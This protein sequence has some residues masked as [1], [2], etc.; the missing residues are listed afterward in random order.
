[1][2]NLLIYL[3]PDHKFNEEYEKLAKIVIENSL[4]YWRKADIMLVTNFPYEFAGVVA[5][6]VG[7]ETICPFY[8]YSGKIN[9]FINLYNSGLI[10]E[11]CWYHDFDAYQLEPFD[12]IDLA[13]VD[14]GFTDYGYRLNWNGGS[15]FLKPGAKDIFV[16]MK[17]LM[18]AYP[19]KTLVNHIEAYKAYSDEVAIKKLT[20]QNF[21]NINDRIKRINISYNF[22][23]NPLTIKNCYE[24]AI[25]PIKVLHC[26]QH[27]LKKS[28][29]GQDLFNKNLI[30][31]F[32]K[33]GYPT[34]ITCYNTII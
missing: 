29:F 19:D 16:W 12:D 21:N 1:M 18:Y 34:I 31:L 28:K 3:S 17:E 5:T 11:T 32:K 8:M 4:N 7:D 22:N 25:K 20:D 6:L 14:V 10:T 13:G 9:A 33:Y 23:L 26:H 24:Q 30:Y 15:S 27:R 2:K